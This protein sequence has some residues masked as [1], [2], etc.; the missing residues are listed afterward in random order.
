MS[1]PM[2]LMYSIN[3]NTPKNGIIRCINKE[4]S[5]MVLFQLYVLVP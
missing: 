5:N 1:K 3:Q 2:Y 4:G